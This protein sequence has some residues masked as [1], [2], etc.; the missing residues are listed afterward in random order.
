MSDPD[1]VLTTSGPT[2]S[3]TTRGPT[4]SSTTSGPTDNAVNVTLGSPNIG[5]VLEHTDQ[6][7]LLTALVITIPGTIFVAV[8]I[9]YAIRTTCKYLAKYGKPNIG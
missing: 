7:T 4:D 3:S 8:G 5:A 2:D 9:I 6:K 1:V